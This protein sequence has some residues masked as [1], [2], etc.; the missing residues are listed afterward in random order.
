MFLNNLFGTKESAQL[1]IEK[2]ITE[3]GILFRIYFKKKEQL[4]LQQ[5]PLELNK[6]LTIKELLVQDQ[7]AKLEVLEQLWLEEWLIAQDSGYLLSGLRLYDLDE[8]SRKELDL[9]QVED[10]IA[11]ELESR[12]AVG[13]KGFEIKYSLNHPKHGY[14]HR[15]GKRLGNLYVINKDTLLLLPKNIQ[16]LIETIDNRPQKVED[17]FGYLALVKK[18][19]TSV[20]ARLDT[21]IQKENYYFPEE[22]DV[23]TEIKNNELIELY[24]SFRDLDNK[25]N[26]EIRSSLFKGASYT[27]ITGPPLQVVV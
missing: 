6:Y 13:T 3:Q 11:I 2:D 4:I 10:N 24:P 9:P 26:N 5:F 25:L 1:Y 12:Q 20:N 19:A 14:F 8:R 17:Q 15:F 22:L 16:K 7:L 23:E 21:Y 27:K 18:L